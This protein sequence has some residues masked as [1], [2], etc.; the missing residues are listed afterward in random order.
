M[1][2]YNFFNIFFC[3]QQIYIQFWTLYTKRAFLQPIRAIGSS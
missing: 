2:I 3:A 1:Q